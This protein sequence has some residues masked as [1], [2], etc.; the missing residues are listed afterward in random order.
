MSEH[1]EQVAL[2][3]W[4]NLQAN[5]DPALRL[6]FAVPNG[7]KRHTV[8]AMRLRDE[9]VKAGVPDILLPVARGGYHGLAIE[10]KHGRNKPTPEQAEW[11]AALAAEGW[12]TCVAYG[13]EEARQAIQD[14]L[15]KDRRGVG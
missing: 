5:R 13:F 6:L 15:F 4:A 1:D 10:M 12:Q 3:D 8:T 2:F 14:Y 11:L 9:G 7:G